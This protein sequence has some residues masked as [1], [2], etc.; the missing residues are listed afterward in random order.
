VQLLEPPL[1]GL[2]LRCAHHFD[3][4]KVRV[5]ARA[6]ASFWLPLIECSR[7]GL[8]WVWRGRCT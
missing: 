4:K 6:S 8:W 7:V 3:H 2:Q 1:D 5:S